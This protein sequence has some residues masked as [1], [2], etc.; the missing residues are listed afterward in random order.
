MFENTIARIFYD[1]IARDLEKSDISMAAFSARV[2]ESMRIFATGGPERLLA[3][4]VSMLEKYLVPH[5]A[6]ISLTSAKIKGRFR[7]YPLDTHTHYI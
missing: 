7:A 3:E 2:E 5:E 6:L 4:L 1:R